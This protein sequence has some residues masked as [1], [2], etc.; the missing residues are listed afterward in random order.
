[1][2]AERG[3]LTRTSQW[4]YWADQ[5][6]DGAFRFRNCGVEGDRTDEIEARFA[7]CTAGADVVVIQGGTNDLAQNRPP[8]AAAA[9]IRD[10][11]ARAKDAGLRTLVTTAPPINVRYPK[12]AP[13]VERLN[14]ADP[15]NREPAGRSGHRF[16]RGARGPGAAGQD[17]R[18]MDRGRN[19]SH[20]P[21]LRPHRPGRGGRAA[22][23]DAAR[24]AFRA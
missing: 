7:D 19:P 21:G 17:A 1:M 5:A 2:I 6:T 4:E 9:N 10:M 22:A 3:E 8:L 13:G 15:G 12:W 14:G 24:A 18:E 20:G 11:V 23:L 16:L